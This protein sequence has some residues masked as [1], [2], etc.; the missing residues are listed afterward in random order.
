MNSVIWLIALVATF[1]NTIHSQ[2]IEKG[3]SSY[4][5]LLVDSMLVREHAEVRIFRLFLTCIIIASALSNPFPNVREVLQTLTCYRTTYLCLFSVTTET[6][7]FKL[8][9]KCTD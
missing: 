3:E 2:T 4:Y 1:I 7:V 8:W 9:V 6:I 5:N